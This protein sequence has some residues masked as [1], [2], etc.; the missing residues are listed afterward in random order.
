M[1]LLTM[2]FLPW[3]PQWFPLVT[4]RYREGKNVPTQE[5][6][7]RKDIPTHTPS[8][9]YLFMHKGKTAVV[10]AA[11]TS[12]VLIPYYICFNTIVFPVCPML[13]VYRRAQR[14]R[15]GT[16]WI[17]IPQSDLPRS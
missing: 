12:L 17:C 5:A 9:Q 10:R 14:P 8:I 13:C 11:A 6:Q 3:P 15:A 2:V 1:A 7:Y 16:V 4:C